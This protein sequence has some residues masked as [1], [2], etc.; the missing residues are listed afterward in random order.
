MMPLTAQEEAVKRLL[1]EE[2]LPFEAHHVFELS[3]TRLS[4]DFLIFLGPGVVIECTACSRKRGSALSEV[5]RRC[6]FMNYRFGLL[7]GSFPKLVCGALVEAPH[8]D[9][10]RVIREIKPILKDSDFLILSSGELRES[11]PKILA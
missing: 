4:V 2:R 5:K 6:A 10:K 1:T 3:S 9:P 7:K 11:L 8:E